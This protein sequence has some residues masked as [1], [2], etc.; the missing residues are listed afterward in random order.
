MQENM[1]LIPGLERSPGEGNGNILQYS[2]LGNPTDRGA[3][4]AVVSP[5]G[6]KESHMTEQLSMS[7]AYHGRYTIFLKTKAINHQRIIY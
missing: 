5:G 7:M 4:R 6:R 2:C 1:G 3:W